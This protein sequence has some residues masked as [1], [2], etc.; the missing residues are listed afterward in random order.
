[1]ENDDQTRTIGGKTAKHRHAHAQRGGM[2]RGDVNM[3]ELGE[4]WDDI[5]GIE[6]AR[7]GREQGNMSMT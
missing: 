7:S 6:P 1:M 4:G 5:I 2:N 3:N